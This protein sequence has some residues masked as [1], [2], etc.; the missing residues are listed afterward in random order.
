MGW[1][2]EVLTHPAL[3]APLPRGDLLQVLNLRWFGTSR[4]ENLILI[5]RINPLLGGA[6]G[7]VSMSVERGRLSNNTRLGS[8]L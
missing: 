3:R 4:S 5:A 8:Q 6:Q 1:L 2:R 7:W